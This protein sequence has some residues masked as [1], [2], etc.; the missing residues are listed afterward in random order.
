MW[1][2]PLKTINFKIIIWAFIFN[3]ILRKLQKPS[4]EY[5]NGDNYILATFQRVK[6]KPPT[7]YV[8]VKTILLKISLLFCAAL[9]T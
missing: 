2:V 7:S 9:V 8:K 6:I 3:K 4:L 5:G 1:F